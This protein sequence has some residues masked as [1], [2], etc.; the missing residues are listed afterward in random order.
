MNSKSIISFIRELYG[1]ANGFIPLH[2]PV[3]QGNEKKYLEECID[4]TF[5]SSVGKFVDSFEEKTA[6]YTG[7]KYAIVCVNGTNALHIALQLSG[8]TADD[9]VITQ[10]LTF[11]ATAN[12]IV[13]A[14]ATPVFVDVD[15]D[16]MGLSPK[17]L[18]SFLEN[19]A[20]VRNKQCFNKKTGRRIKA[21]MPMHTFGHACRIEEI[22]DICN[23]YHIELVEDAAEAMGSFYKGKHLGTFGK[24]GAISFN[25]NKIM[26]TGGGGIILTNDEEMAKKAKHLTTQ[27]KLPHKWE[28]VHD[29]IGYNY[30]M[31][32]LNA[33][34]G[35]AQLE[36]LNSFLENKRKTAEAYK[37]FFVKMNIP[38]FVERAEEKCNYWLNAI[39]LK[40]KTER[41]SFLIES[42]ENKVMTRP[43]WKLMNHLP[44]FKNCP[45]GDLSNA[46]W[47]EERVVNI[48]SSVK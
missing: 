1:N 29:E 16:T 11:I 30:R 10:P 43:I 12:S 27:A 19:S 22:I 32:N 41:D 18:L 40:D 39:I 35:L 45:K 15:K 31:P 9:E 7:A 44:M 26:T 24:I 34:V 48:P 17:A 47:L 28:F 8:V 3:F 14:G 13:Y 23:V 5:V 2:A 36:Q 38:F 4:T 37:Q 46:E 6:Q 42:N 33:A 21:C 20:E 25:G